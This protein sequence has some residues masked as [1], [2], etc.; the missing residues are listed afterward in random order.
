MSAKEKWS[1]QHM[2]AVE[3]HGR[4]TDMKHGD[5]I[6]EAYFIL[7]V[8]L[9]PRGAGKPQPSAAEI[10]RQ[11][12]PRRTSSREQRSAPSASCRGGRC[13]SSQL[14]QMA[15]LSSVERRRVLL[16][17]VTTCRSGLATARSSPPALD[18]DRR[19]AP[20]GERKPRGARPFVIRQTPYSFDCP[21]K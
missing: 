3:G 8:D 10:T 9:V 17:Y 15:Q 1:G 14:R 4:V 11:P 12:P 6:T 19:S 5:M 18:Q 16:P 20:Q 21:N 7:D 13:A 2:I